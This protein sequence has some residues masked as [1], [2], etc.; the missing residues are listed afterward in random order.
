MFRAF[1]IGLLN[2]FIYL[3]NGDTQHHD[4]ANCDIVLKIMEQ[5]ATKICSLGTSWDQRSCMPSSVNVQPTIVNLK[6]LYTKSKCSCSNKNAF[7]EF[8]GEGTIQVEGIC[9]LDSAR[10]N[11]NKNTEENYGKIGDY[12]IRT[13]NQTCETMVGCDG[14]V[15]DFAV[16]STVEPG[17][18]ISPN[19]ILKNET[20]I[21]DDDDAVM[22]NAVMATAQ[23]LIYSIDS[24][25]SSVVG[26]TAAS[27]GADGILG[28]NVEFLPW[29]REVTLNG[30]LT[31]DS[32]EEQKCCMIKCVETL[33]K[34]NGHNTVSESDIK[35]CKAICEKSIG[36]GNT[37]CEE[38]KQ[39]C[40]QTCQKHQDG[41]VVGNPAVKTCEGACKVNQIAQ[42]IES[43]T[44][45]KIDISKVVAARRLYNKNP[46]KGIV[47]PG[48]HD[49]AKSDDRVEVCSDGN[50]RG[51]VVR[52]IYKGSSG[53]CTGTLVGPSHV[54]TAGHC[55]YSN[56]DGKWLEIKG[57]LLTPCK[58]AHSEIE[59]K[60]NSPRPSYWSDA[61]IDFGWEWART[62]KGWTK[63]GKW[64]YDYGMIKLHIGD[65]Q[66]TGRGWMSFGYDNS[67]PKYS[68]NLNGYPGASAP[69]TAGDFDKLEL[70]DTAGEKIQ[71]VYWTG[72][73]MAWDYD[74][75]RAVKDKL[76]EYYIDTWGGQ[77]GS[78]VYAYF[79][80]TNRRII[81]GVHRGWDGS[82]GDEENN[83][84]DKSEYNVAKRITRQTFGQLC[85]WIN[86]ARVC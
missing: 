44:A 19:S 84:Q 45:E 49:P 8:C 25:K 42:P 32:N 35:I 11:N 53:V 67:L 22:A 4:L 59:Q 68:F 15:T 48:G 82:Q 61:P 34:K 77:S 18:G 80:Q 31:T 72:F 14:T 47:T 79:P 71:D 63:N 10:D 50:P 24:T 5:N 36:N 6:L 40:V 1:N 76:L 29:H 66:Q 27:S 75:T 30:E 17:I 78:A 65:K 16:K 39:N 56:K 60:P 62:V 12:I 58:S 20:D 74:K 46:L 57:V 9:V 41:I 55:L 2:F 38:Q 28:N 51:K 83:P 43:N 52:I 81:Y 33:S 85:G 70:K 3:V 13:T 69:I 21:D 64:E 23:E 86:D 73:E 37:F 26:N 7:I 54:L